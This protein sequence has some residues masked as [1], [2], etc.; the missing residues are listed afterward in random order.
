MSNNTDPTSLLSER[1]EVELDE[2]SVIE[3]SICCILNITL[4]IN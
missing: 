2:K 4:R 3:F 1:H